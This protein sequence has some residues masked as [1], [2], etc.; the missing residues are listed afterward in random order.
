MQRL[1]KKIKSSHSY[2][3]RIK[4]LKNIFITLALILIIFS[5]V[6]IGFSESREKSQ[7]GNNSDEFLDSKYKISNL[8]FT[9]SFD[10]AKEY[11]LFSPKYTELSSNS[12][13]DRPILH[14]LENHLIDSIINAKKGIFF[15]EGKKLKLS[16]AIELV[17]QQHFKLLN[18]ESEVNL[19]TMTI[20]SDKFTK[21]TW[22][23]SYLNSPKGFI[24]NFKQKTAKLFGPIIGTYYDLHNKEIAFEG[25]IL[26][27]YNNNI[28]LEKK[29][30]VAM[31]DKKLITHKLLFDNI[32]NITHII[33]GVKF[34]TAQEEVIATNGYIDF[35]AKKLYLINN[36]ILKKRNTTV[37]GQK[38]IYDYISNESSIISDYN[39]SN[40][41][42]ISIN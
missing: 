5:L 35:T 34:I 23:K 28:S 40:R 30:V 12:I 9:K 11:K 32:K 17:Y 37:K 3:K 2:L 21:V 18:E 24:V 16:D 19:Q 10:L 1:N 31:E 41:V 8:I 25:E 15:A 7:S 38:F 22:D 29:V 20:T 33:G 26:E 4:Y 39:K 6:T 42:Q 14:I 13:I 36:V 27:I